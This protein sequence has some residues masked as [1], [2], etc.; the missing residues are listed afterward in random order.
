[1]AMNY[2]TS[3]KNFFGPSLRDLFINLGLFGYMVIASWWTF[4]MTDFP[5]LPLGYL[6]GFAIVCSIGGLLFGGLEGLIKGALVIPFAIGSIC[7]VFF[8]IFFIAY[9]IGVVSAFL[10]TIPLPLVGN[11]RTL[12]MVLLFVLFL[13]I[14]SIG[15]W[16]D[17]KLSKEHDTIDESEDY[18]SRTFTMDLWGGR[19][20]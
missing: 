20:G 17:F 9:L 3:I 1:M 15:I 19:W 6:V 10:A 4:N 2:V 14:L 16:A 13:F 5:R 7:A 11:A 8:P 12:A 18:S